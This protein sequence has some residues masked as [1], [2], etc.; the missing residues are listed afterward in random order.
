MLAWPL[1][2]LHSDVSGSGLLQG[3][4]EIA[5]KKKMR[6]GEHMSANMVHSGLEM[7]GNDFCSGDV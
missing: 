5:Q 4:L 2:S 6:A 3:A 7:I 1:N